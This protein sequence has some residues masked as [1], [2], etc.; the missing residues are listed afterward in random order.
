[1]VLYSNHVNKSRISTNPFYAVFQKFAWFYDS[2]YHLMGLSDFSR[3]DINGNEQDGAKNPFNFVLAP[4]Q[5]GIFGCAK[6]TIEDSKYTCLKNIEKNTEIFKIW[7]TPGPTK[8]SEA[9]KCGG[10]DLVGS[11]TTVSE[12]TDSPYMDTHVRMKHVF[13]KEEM[14]NIVNTDG[15]NLAARWD[16]EHEAGPRKWNNCFGMA[17]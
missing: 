12:F 9:A 8:S 17:D 10:L 13:W 16:Y 6:G 2:D 5:E 4:T 15:W 11:I 3:W 1:M 7:E 14:A